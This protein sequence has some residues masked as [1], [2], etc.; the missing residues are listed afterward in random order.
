M[1]GAASVLPFGAAAFP[2]GNTG[3][4]GVNLALDGGWLLR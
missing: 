1:A 3:V 4:N 2:L